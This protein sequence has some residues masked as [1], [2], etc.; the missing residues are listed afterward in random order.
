MSHSS[1]T[2]MSLILHG[3]WA[4]DLLLAHTWVSVLCLASPERGL[5][6]QSEVSLSKFP[7]TAQHLSLAELE[8]DAKQPRRWGQVSQGWGQVDTVTAGKE[9]HGSAPAATL[10]GLQDPGTEVWRPSWPPQQ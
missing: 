9:E 4:T 5:C 1:H 3:T 8:S 2:R 7:R 6:H 10:R